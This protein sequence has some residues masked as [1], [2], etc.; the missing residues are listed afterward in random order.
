[1][2]AAEKFRSFRFI[3]VNSVKRHIFNV[4]I[5]RL[6]HALPTSKKRRVISS[7]REGFFFSG[8]FTHAKFCENK[9]LAKITEF[10]VTARICYM[11]YTTTNVCVFLYLQVTSTERY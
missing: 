11:T 3:F 8:K 5:S 4:K 1:M 7:F 10:I 6:E 9:T 2:G